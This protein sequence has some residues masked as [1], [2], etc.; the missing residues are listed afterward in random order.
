MSNKEDVLWFSE[1]L[2]EWYAGNKRELP[3]RQTTDPYKIWLSEIILQQ[4]RV[5]Q[6]QPYYLRFIEHYP[7]V[8]DLAKASEDQ[9]LKDWQG[10][11]YYSRARNLHTAAKYVAEHLNGVMPADYEGLRALKGVGDYT[12]ADIAALAYNLPYAATDG[13]VYRVLSRVFGISTP[14]DS[15]TGK[16]EFSALASTLLSVEHPGDFNQALMDL[17]ATVCTPKN[18]N[19]SVCPMNAKCYALSTNKQSELPV[20]S[21]KT[22]VRDRYFY[23]FLIELPDHRIIVNQR[24]GKDIWTG[25]YDF[26]LVESDHALSEEELFETEAYKQL[27]TRAQGLTIGKIGKEHKHQLSHQTIYAKLLKCKADKAL[28]LQE[29]KKV[30][31]EEFDNLAIPKL[32]EIIIEKA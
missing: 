23:Y 22:Q 11:G 27:V 21:K 18:Y 5:E 13:N 15:T 14:I 16:K 17:G 30:T 32:I 25:L 1:L 3:W 9:V 7:T 2:L 20:K 8:T 31:K 10:L 24:K 12:A 26:P 28:L 19:C 4:T 6:G 29:E